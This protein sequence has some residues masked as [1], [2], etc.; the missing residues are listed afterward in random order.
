MIAAARTRVIRLRLRV[1]WFFGRR[2][3]VEMLDH[4]VVFQEIEPFHHRIVLQQAQ[5]VRAELLFHRKLF[6]R[7]RLAR[8]RTHRKNQC[9]RDAGG[10]QRRPS[11]QPK[12]MAARA[13]SFELAPELAAIR[14][15]VGRRQIADSARY[16]LEDRRERIELRAASR[17]SVQMQGYALA[18]GLAQLAA[19]IGH[20]REVRMRVGFHSPLLSCLLSTT[21]PRWMWTR[22]VFSEQLSTAAI[23]RLVSPSWTCRSTAAR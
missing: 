1:M 4:V 23:S 10:S 20:Q 19:K 9:R 16:P 2:K 6:R 15:P 12:P 21:R 3:L 22:A 17:A 7:H 11:R 13:A 14:N 5:I 8:R 18:F